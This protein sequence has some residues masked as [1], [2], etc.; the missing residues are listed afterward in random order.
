MTTTRSDRKTMTCAEFQDRLP[1]LFESHADLSAEE[2]LKTC[3]NCAALVRDLEYIAQQAK[4]LLPIH[5]PSPAV[6]D[7]IENAIQTEGSGQERAEANRPPV[8]A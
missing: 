8:R 1:E 4:L 5:D 2:H 6:W 3:E 7:K